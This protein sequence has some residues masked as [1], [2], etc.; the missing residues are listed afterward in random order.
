MSQNDTQKIASGDPEALRIGRCP[1]CGGDRSTQL[2]SVP[3]RSQRGASSYAL[4][5]CPS[6]LHIWLGNRP[7]PEEMSQYYGATYHRDIGHSGETSPKRWAQHVQV[8]S[9]YKIGGSVLDIGCSSGGF[10]GYLRGG[11]W[12]L[13]GIEASQHAAERA[14]ARTG[15]DVFAGDVLNAKFPPDSFDVITCMDVLEHVY[16]PREVLRNVCNWLKPGGMFYVFVPNIMSWEARIFRSYWYGLDLPRHVHHFTAQSL[17]ELTRSVGL[18]Q[19]SLATPA[20]CYL[21]ESTWILCDDL[22]RRAGLWWP[23]WDWIAKPGIAWRIV[24]KGLRLSVEALYSVVASRFGAAA[25]LQAVFE[26]DAGPDSAGDTL[27]GVQS[28]AELAEVGISSA[29]QPPLVG[30]EAPGTVK[31]GLTQ[32]TAHRGQTFTPHVAPKPVTAFGKGI[33][34]IDDISPRD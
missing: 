29:T 9:K 26:K 25:S 12:K 27:A 19:V 34:R 16:E 5:Q 32:G 20:G 2:M 13:H 23:S 18:R 7:T 24:R 14:R 8:L 30:M 3:D 15:A 33:E 31:S 11:P 10:L 28:S 1:C 4:L 17:A 6:C 22:A 21:E